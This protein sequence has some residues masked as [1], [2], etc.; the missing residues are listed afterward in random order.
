MNAMDIDS[1]LYIYCLTA[2]KAFIAAFAVQILFTCFHHDKPTVVI[3]FILVFVCRIY[4]NEVILFFGM[5]LINLIVLLNFCK[6]SIFEVL[7]NQH[8]RLS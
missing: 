7:Q 2:F 5:T 1:L 8:E 3:V 4:H 6:Y